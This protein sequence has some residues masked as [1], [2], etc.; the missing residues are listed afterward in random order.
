MEVYKN[1]YQRSMD[2]WAETTLKIQDGAAQWFP[3]EGV[4]WASQLTLATW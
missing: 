3:N 2:M 1:V 4:R